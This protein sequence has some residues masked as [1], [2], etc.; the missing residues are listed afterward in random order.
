MYAFLEGEVAEKGFG[1]IV[2]NV[3]GVGYLVSCS[4]NTL[5]S[6]PQA[7]ERV[8]IFT[9]LS[10][11]EDAMEL[12]GFLTKSEKDMF[13][14]LVSVSGVGSRTALGL[15]G[16]MPLRDLQLAILTEDI[17]ALSRAPGIGKKTAQRIALEL[18]DKFT[19][20]EVAQNAGKDAKPFTAAAAD[21]GTGEALLALQA[22]GYTPQEAAR[23]VS[24]VKGEAKDQSDIIRLALRHMAG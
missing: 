12:F 22:L 11:R 13:L 1:E 18:K 2:I 19:D 3:G 8:K 6:C 10:V 24:A 5:S 9:Y 16:A 17:T 21:D 4:A 20:S 15:L 23:A 14:H 7:G